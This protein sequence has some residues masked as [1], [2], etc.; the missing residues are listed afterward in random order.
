MHRINSQAL[1]SPDNAAALRAE[2]L[3][4]PPGC[5][6]SGLPRLF[7]WF[8]S[9]VSCRPGSGYRGAK[10]ALREREFHLSC[11]NLR[12][13]VRRLPYL[14]LRVSTFRHSSST[15]SKYGRRFEREEGWGTASPSF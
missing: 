4:P 9:A 14:G 6:A 11:L 13:A 1:P 12:F 5:P 2:A 15:R 3:A 10:V 7:S 8:P